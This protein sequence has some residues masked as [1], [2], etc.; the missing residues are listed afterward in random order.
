MVL[1]FLCISKAEQF[2]NSCKYQAALKL[3]S[4]TLSDNSKSLPNQNYENDQLQISKVIKSRNA[5]IFTSK[6]RPHILSFII[7]RWFTFNSLLN[8]VSL[9]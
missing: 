4:D 6:R 9:P 5:F 8:S 7:I 2:K 1:K 3:E